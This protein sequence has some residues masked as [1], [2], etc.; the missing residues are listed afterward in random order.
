MYRFHQQGHCLYFMMVINLISTHPSFPGQKKRI[1]C[2]LCFL[3]T[4]AMSFIPL[5][6]GCFGPF[7]KILDNITHKWLR[8]NPGQVI[9]K[10]NIAS[11]AYTSGLSPTNLQSSFKNVA[12]THSTL[13]HMTKIKLNLF[14][15]S[16]K[17][18]SNK[19]VKI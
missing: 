18:N 5:D 7:Q 2:C 1:L 9:S 12:Y 11:K 16:K 6:V 14:R 19:Q 8:D 15:Y 3:P 4:L 17:L 10:H 13:K